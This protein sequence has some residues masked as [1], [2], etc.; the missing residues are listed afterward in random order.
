MATDL[1][2]YDYTLAWICALPLELAAA[3]AVLD[4]IHPK[5]PASFPVQFSYT[6]GKIDNNNIVLA[7]LPSGRYGTSPATAVVTHLQANFPNVRVGLMVGIGGGVPSDT[8]DIQLGDVVVSKPTGT[9]GENWHAEPTAAE[10]PDCSLT[11]RGQLHARKRL[12]Y[13]MEVIGKSLSENPSMEARFSRPAHD[14]L[15]DASYDHPD[16]NA[17]CTSCDPNMQIKRSARDFKD[18]RIHYGIIASGNQVMKHGPIRDRIAKELNALC[19][20]ME[21]AGIMNFLPCLVIRGICDYCDTHK[22]KDWQD[23]AAL[24]AAA[25]AKVVLSFVPGQDYESSQRKTS[26]M[27]PFGR[28][29]NFLGR[30]RE[31]G[32]LLALVKSKGRARKAAVRGLGGVGKTQI[33]LEMAYRMRVERRDCSIFWIASTSVEAVEQA[34]IA[35]SIELR[36]EKAKSDEKSR[37]KEYLSSDKAGPWVL[38]VDNADSTD[39]WMSNTSSPGLKNFLPYSQKG[40]IVFTTRNQVAELS[41]QTAI[42]LL[43]TLL[44]DSSCMIDRQSATRLVQQLAG[45]PLALIQAASFMN[46]NMVTLTEYLALLSGQESITVELLTRTNPIAST[47]L[48]CFRKVRSL[49]ALADIPLL[50]LPPASST[51]EQQKALGI[52]KSYSFVTQMSDNRNLNMHRLVH[53]ASRNWLRNEGT[54]LQLTLKTEELQNRHLLRSYLPHAEYLLQSQEPLLEQ[55]IWDV[56]A[57]KVGISLYQ[58]SRFHEAEYLFQS[59]HGRM[60]RS[61]D[62][63]DPNVLDILARL[64]LTLCNAG[65]YKEAES[66]LLEAIEILT[67]ILG[68]EHRVVLGAKASL[69]DIYLFQG[70]LYEARELILSVTETRRRALGLKHPDTVQSIRKLKELSAIEITD[71]E[72]ALREIEKNK[73]TVGSGHPTTLASMQALAKIYRDLGRLDEAKRL[74]TQV[75]VG[76]TATLGPAAISTLNHQ[77]ALGTIYQEQRRLHEAEETYLHILKTLRETLGPERTETISALCTVAILYMETN[78]LEQGEKLLSEALGEGSSS[79]HPVMS[80]GIRSLARIWKLQGRD[81]EAIKLVRE[82]LKLQLGTL[83]SSH[84]VTVESVKLPE[85]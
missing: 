53:L 37:V 43:T 7:C 16:M 51:I 55:E 60:M 11:G 5:L 36:L 13:H 76:L 44:I 41:D 65:R 57:H 20:E 31:L 8:T 6:L 42:Y 63:K 33:V 83:G 21:A 14:S 28:N 67:G 4:E 9:C 73:T 22:N 68:P 48:M 46:E 10:P 58:D 81:R 79:D 71:E 15:F 78:R 34:F 39:M 30:E 56:L 17:S 45:L 82:C 64:I 80:I 77:S 23:Y 50:I 75:V 66:I 25:Y 47:W 29:P 38:I 26:F 18:Q 85:E 19:F 72:G 59:L 2:H 12:S 3:S 24:A 62:G 84:P 40:F 61:W 54:L 74:L 1:S 49:N 32:H 69:V 35:R 52:Q 70:R 27:V